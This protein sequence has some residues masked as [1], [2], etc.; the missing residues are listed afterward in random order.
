MKKTLVITTHH[1]LP[2]TTGANMRTMHFVRFF[3]QLGQ[4]DLVYTFGSGSSASGESP[5]RSESQIGLRANSGFAQ[6]F[7]EGV[8]R[9][10]PV[11]VYSY[12]GQARDLLVRLIHDQAYDYVLIRSAYAS[13][14]L[15][16]LP[17]AVLSRSI[18]D[19]DDSIS[20]SLYE[21]FLAD[22]HGARRLL[23]LFNRLLVR[24]HEER[25]ARASAV[26]LI[27][28]EKDRARLTNSLGSGPV[29][30]PNVFSPPGPHPTVR[31]LDGFPRGNR[32][33]FVGTLSYAPNEEGLRW[34]LADV[35]GPFRLRFPDAS[36]TV[37]G[38]SPSASLAALCE[39]TSG[40]ELHA[41]VDD[42]LHFYAD[43]RAVVVPLRSGGGTRVKILESAFAKRPVLSTAVGADGLDFRDGSEVLLFENAEEF[44]EAYGRLAERSVYQGLVS[45]AESMLVAKYSP[46]VF[47]ETMTAAL[48]RIG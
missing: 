37:V 44:I 3:R 45:A 48:A 16:D 17:K 38:R 4:V 19:L 7:I 21:Q 14:V 29:L 18:L 2:E 35:F 27:C 26:C 15:F 36:L 47:D 43:S 12:H 11:P 1:P 6:R 23:L 13:G 41:D 42:V 33:L 46:A 24:A 30:V 40:V 5:F 31:S 10:R 28:N 8:L 34:F 20:D 9:G 25:S 32:L 39:T 22:V